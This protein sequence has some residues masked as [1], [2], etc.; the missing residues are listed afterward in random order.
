MFVRTVEKRLSL[1]VS[2]A[3]PVSVYNKDMTFLAGGRTANISESG[4]MAVVRGCPLPTDV[5]VEI[6]LPSG[7]SR[8]RNQTRTVLYRARVIR[9]QVLGNLMGLGV[10]LIEKVE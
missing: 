3:Y 5:L 7:S 9:Q 10:Q 4:L 1:R 6:T 2:A 8:V